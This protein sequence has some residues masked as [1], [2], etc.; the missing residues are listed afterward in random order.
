MEKLILTIVTG[1]SENPW[2]RWASIF[3]W[4]NPGPKSWRVD[5]A[6]HPKTFWGAFPRQH[7]GKCVEGGDANRSKGST[8]HAT[9]VAVLHPAA[10]VSEGWGF[11]TSSRT[12]RWE[13]GQLSTENQ[14]KRGSIFQNLTHCPWLCR[15]PPAQHASKSPAPVSSEHYKYGPALYG[16]HC[17]SLVITN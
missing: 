8:R 1:S 6:S 14:K 5:R 12:I 2:N 10:P 16:C 9:L 4:K 11:N 17:I 13:G 3:P 15:Y 7:L